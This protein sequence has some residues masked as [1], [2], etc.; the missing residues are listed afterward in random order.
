ME[1]S[2]DEGEWLSSPAFEAEAGLQEQLLAGIPYQTEVA[3]RVVLGDEALDGAT[4]QTGRVPT[5]LPTATVEGAQPEAWWAEGRYL[6]TSINQVQ[7]GWTGGRYWTVIIDRRGRPVWAQ[8][9]PEGN[10]TLFPQVSAGG[11]A[12][13]W[14]EA[15][16]W[17]QWDQG[18][19]SQVHRTWLDEEIEVIP[20]PG[21]HHAFVELPDGTL[22]WGSK[23][24]AERTEALVERAPGAEEDRVIWT[25]AGDWPGVNGCES[26]GLFYVEATDSFLYSFYTNN[27]VVEVDRA[28]GA[29]LWWAGALAGGY[30]FDPVESRFSWQHGITLT[31]A[32]T[33]L[34]STTNGGTTGVK[35]YEIDHDARALRQ[36]WS[37]D[38]GVLANTNGDAWRLPNGDTLH[39]LGSAG[40]LVEVDPGGQVVW[41]VD[42]HGE[43]LLGRGELV[44]D[45]YALVQPR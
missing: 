29:S 24:H 4:L 10:W 36:V 14:D 25:C 6:L 7:G 45:L 32:G 8:L 19:G 13:L 5:G 43:R 42:F 11:D 28:T 16:A 44:P 2:F 38:S 33:L 15:T 21:L 3:W 41:S 12:I 37:F 34:V 30:A 27:T 9:A 31:P 20:T 18:A 22:V 40:C 39:L 35:E 23:H 1:Y 26:N 17:S